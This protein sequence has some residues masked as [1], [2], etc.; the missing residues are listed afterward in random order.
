MVS[1]CK[2]RLFARGTRYSLPV[3]IATLFCTGGCQQRGADIQLDDPELA[4]FVRL[5]TP[6]QIE[7]QDFT[8]PFDFEG[9]GN[10]DGLEAVLAV[11]DSFDDRIKCTGT[12]HF[13]LH[14]MRTASGDKL[15][16]RIAFW[17]LAIDSD[18][19]VGQYWER[20]SRYYCF[21]LRLSSGTLPPGRC[22][23]TARL[24]TPTGDKLFD[25]HELTYEGPRAGGIR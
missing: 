5:M 18:K 17:S 22:I 12:F 13:E 25:D 8:K 14:T 19:T 24:I 6:R 9:T 2:N 11:L 20:S 21:P 16:K 23:L 4:A 15:G 1:K 3:A 7:I 10:A